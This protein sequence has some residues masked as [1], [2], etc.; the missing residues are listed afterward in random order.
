[1]YYMELALG[2]F[3]SHGSVKVWSV[4]PA[5]KGECYEGCL[6]TVFKYSVTQTATSHELLDKYF[7]PVGIL[8]W[9]KYHLRCSVSAYCLPHAICL[10]ASFWSTYTGFT[11]LGLP[12]VTT[13]IRGTGI[14]RLASPV[15]NMHSKCGTFSPHVVSFA[16]NA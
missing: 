9:M 13:A 12:Q 14:I 7:K 10:L 3:S 4:V 11:K 15:L 5:F 6:T 1:M 8:F 2:Q 16:R